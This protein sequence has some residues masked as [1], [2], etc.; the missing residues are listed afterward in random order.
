M[1]YFKFQF[2]LV[3]VIIE[4]LISLIIWIK[5]TKSSLHSSLTSTL[6]QSI[7]TMD[8]NNTTY[9][10]GRN[11]MHQ[12]NDEICIGENAKVTQ[13]DSDF[14]NDNVG[15]YEEHIE[16]PH[17]PILD[18]NVASNNSCIRQ[19]ENLLK[20]HTR[21]PPQSSFVPFDSNCP[22]QRRIF[23]RCDQVELHT[24]ERGQELYRDP[25]GIN[26][27]QMLLKYQLM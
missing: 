5:I 2:I 25:L 13:H 19:R 16:A 15:D 22:K 26:I 20:G 23:N 18:V 4:Q 1:V 17:F 10:S 8:S 3:F 21:S 7:T 9:D 27:N 11:L 14:K 6:H 24:L 12:T